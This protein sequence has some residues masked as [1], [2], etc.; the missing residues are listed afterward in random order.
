M[1]PVSGRRESDIERKAT[2]ER[3]LME[4]QQS[5]SG[6]IV[7]PFQV[8]VSKERNNNNNGKPTC[9]TILCHVS[10]HR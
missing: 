9:G 6:T 7:V 4:S 8:L 2:I 3:L 1:L 5:R 10:S